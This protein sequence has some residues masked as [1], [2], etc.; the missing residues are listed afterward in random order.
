MGK[1][2]DTL[3]DHLCPEMHAVAKMAKNRQR[4]GD[5]NWTP[6]VA[7]WREAMLTIIAILAKMANLA[8]METK[9]LGPL[10]SGNLAKW[11]L[12]QKWR[13]IA[14]GW[15]YPACGNIIQIGFKSMII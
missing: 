2:D 5:S 12:W 9:S 7:P 10:E 1:I 4:A 3:Q 11:Q 14:R 15:Q 8:Q 13:K 6:K